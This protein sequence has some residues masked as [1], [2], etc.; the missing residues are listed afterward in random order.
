V[1][2]SNARSRLQLTTRLLQIASTLVCVL[3]AFPRSIVEAGA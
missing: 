1:K 3:Y 2:T